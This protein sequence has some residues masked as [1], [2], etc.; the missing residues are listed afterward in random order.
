MMMI[1]DGHEG[2]DDDDDERGV[3]RLLTSLSRVTMTGAQAVTTSV[4][5]MMMVMMMSIRII[6]IK[7]M[8][9]ITTGSLGGFRAPTSSLEAFFHFVFCDLRALK[10]CDPNK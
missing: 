4:V 2:D 10:L 7:I 1:D 8:I 6:V 5:M 3:Q 9:F